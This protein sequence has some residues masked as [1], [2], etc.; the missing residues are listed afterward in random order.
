MRSITKVPG[1]CNSDGAL[2]RV[3]KMNR[4]L[5]RFVYVNCGYGE[6]Q[7]HSVWT[8]SVTV[9]LSLLVSPQPSTAVASAKFTTEPLV[10]S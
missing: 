10:T 6:H 9:A 7:Q 4:W 8:M 2:A 1:P 5:S 3:S